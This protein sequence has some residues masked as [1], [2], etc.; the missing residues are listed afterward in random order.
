MGVGVGELSE[1]MKAGGLAPP[2]S[3]VAL[4]ELAKGSAGELAL[5]VW[6]QESQLDSQ[7]S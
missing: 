6:V 5:M 4:G 2:L 7:L 1:G 3:A